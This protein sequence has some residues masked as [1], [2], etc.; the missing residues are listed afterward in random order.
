[1]RTKVFAYKGWV[2][3]QSDVNAEGLLNKPLDKGQLGFVLN[4][5]F[6]DISPEAL[7]LLKKFLYQVIVSVMLISSNLKKEQYFPGLVGL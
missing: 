5:S 6:V 3:I 4:A 7:E 2:D 1:M